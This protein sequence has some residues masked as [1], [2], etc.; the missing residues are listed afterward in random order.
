MPISQF[1]M[2]VLVAE[3]ELYVVQNNKLQDGQVSC[4]LSDC[5]LKAG[6]GLEQPSSEH[7]TR[8]LSMPSPVAPDCTADFEQ[9]CLSSKLCS[10]QNDRVQRGHIIGRKS[11]VL[12]PTNAQ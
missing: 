10:L 4:E 5:D 6:L 8:E 12:Q 9:R 11:T 3:K 1:N 2:A 7:G